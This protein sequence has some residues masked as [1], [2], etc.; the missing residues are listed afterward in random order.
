MSRLVSSSLL[1]MAVACNPS[2]EV[3]FDGEEAG[4]LGI[5]GTSASDVWVVGADAGDGPSVMHFNGQDWIR[6]ATGT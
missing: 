5:T 1:L 2:L 3:S 4:L 6:K